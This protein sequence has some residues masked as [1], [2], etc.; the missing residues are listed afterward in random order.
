MLNRTIEYFLDNTDMPRFIVITDSLKDVTL[1]PS[2]H[3][4]VGELEPADA[5]QLLLLCASQYIDEYNRD[6]SNLSNHEIFSIISRNPSSIVRF[7]QFLKSTPNTLDAIVNKEK[8]KIRELN[9]NVDANQEEAFDVDES[10]WVIKQS[11]DLL[12]KAHGDKI[13]ILFVICQLPNGVFDS[14]LEAIFSSII[15]KWKIFIS[16]LIKQKNRQGL[17]CSNSDS[18]S[19]ENDQETSWLI[20]SEPIEEIS[21]NRYYAYQIVYSFI[22]RTIIT[23]EERNEACQLVLSHLSKLSRKIMRSMRRTEIKILSLS[24]FTALIDVGL[25]SDEE[26][27]EDP[28]KYYRD[29]EDLFEDPKVYFSYHEPNIQKFL[30]IEFIRIAFPLKGKTYSKFF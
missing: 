12:I 14:D 29:Y 27:F 6:I 20:T 2:F 1:Q 16:A 15:P 9:T 5:S 24:K 11:Y 19:E 10:S 30:D 25:W 26:D 18:F 4:E 3:Y 21:V 7:S 17:D 23:Q 22:N 13:M 8:E 28:S